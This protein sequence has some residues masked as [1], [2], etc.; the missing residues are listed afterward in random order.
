MFDDPTTGAPRWVF[1]FGVVFL[2]LVLMFVVLHLSGGGP[3]R[4][5]L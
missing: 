2:V 5:A 4:H 3:G 1:M